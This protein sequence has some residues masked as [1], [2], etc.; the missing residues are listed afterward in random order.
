[1]ARSKLKSVL[2][3]SKAFKVIEDFISTNNKDNPISF[4]KAVNTIIEQYK[5]DTNK[6]KISSKLEDISTE[7]KSLNNRI[8]KLFEK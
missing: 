7:L 3:T 5:R 4:N 1:M 8:S 2:F 6:E